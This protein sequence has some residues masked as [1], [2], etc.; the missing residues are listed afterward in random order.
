[1]PGLAFVLRCRRSRAAARD[2]REGEARRFARTI[3]QRVEGFREGMAAAGLPIDDSLFMQG[4]FDFASGIACAEALLQRADRP[5]AI[6][7]TNDPMAL[8]VLTL[9]HDL[10]LRVPEDLSVAGFDDTRRSGRRSPR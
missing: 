8:G 10:G 9:A 6:F 2:Q 5:T 4:S 7:A 3:D 1:M